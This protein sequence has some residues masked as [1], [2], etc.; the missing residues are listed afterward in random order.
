M[1]AN[2]ANPVGVWDGPFPI[3][4]FPHGI[5]LQPYDPDAILDIGPDYFVHAPTAAADLQ[6]FNNIRPENWDAMPSV[7]VNLGLTSRELVSLYLL[8][9]VESPDL[10]QLGMVQGCTCG[11]VPPGFVA[12]R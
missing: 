2:L 8:S 1:L 3:E 4:V 9:N 6:A 12:N 11:P 10:P 7:L 5:G